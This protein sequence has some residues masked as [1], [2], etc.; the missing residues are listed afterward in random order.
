[1]ESFAG[2]SP[3]FRLGFTIVTA[4]FVFTP[5]RVVGRVGSPCTAGWDYGEAA[6]W[7]SSTTDRK[8]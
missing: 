7:L 1:M 6:A 3:L 4:R 8:D 5:R 2:T